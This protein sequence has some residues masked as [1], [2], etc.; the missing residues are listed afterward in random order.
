M[1]IDLKDTHLNIELN[2]LIKSLEKVDKR[3]S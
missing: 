3:K 2:E 1:M